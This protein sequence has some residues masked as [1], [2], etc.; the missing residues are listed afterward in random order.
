METEYDKIRSIKDLESIKKEYE[1]LG[2]NN[3]KKN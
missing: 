1:K 2:E 3:K